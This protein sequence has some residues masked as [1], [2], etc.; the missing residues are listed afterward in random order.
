MTQDQERE[1]SNLRAEVECLK[2]RVNQNEDRHV[3]LDQRV[4]TVFSWPWKRL[5]WIACGWRPYSLG[6][7]RRRLLFR[8]SA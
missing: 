7:W 2:F 4:D 8:R 1:L 5:W 3:A 6:R